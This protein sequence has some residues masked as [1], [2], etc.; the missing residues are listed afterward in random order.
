MSFHRLGAL[1]QALTTGE[2]AHHSRE[3]V[4][5]TVRGAAAAENPRPTATV[6]L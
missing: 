6:V 5:A 4:H 1:L 3:P 2:A